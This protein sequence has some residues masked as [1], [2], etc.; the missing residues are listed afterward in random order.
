MTTTTRAKDEARWVDV[1]VPIRPGMPTFEG[2]PEV[3]L[4]RAASLAAGDVCNVSRLDFGLAPYHAVR[5]GP[6]CTL[7]GAA[8]RKSPC[9]DYRRQAAAEWCSKQG[10]QHSV[11]TA[12]RSRDSRT[13]QRSNH[14]DDHHPR[15]SVTHHL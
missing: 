3:R 14:V 5:D 15:D 8:G 13:E 9:R 12:K 4:E 6:G 11:G 10:R 1:S 7:D 2:D